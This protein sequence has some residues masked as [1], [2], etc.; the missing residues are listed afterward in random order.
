MNK[1]TN[2]WKHIYIA[3]ALALAYVIAR[4]YIAEL[5]TLRWVAVLVWAI[6]CA[7]WEYNQWMSHGCKKGYWQ[8]RGLDTVVDLGTGIGCFALIVLVSWSWSVAWIFLAT[9]IWGREI[10]G[11]IKEMVKG[12]SNAEYN[13]AE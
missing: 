6:L 3:T 8:R 7:S 9:V 11:W 5:H 10:W 13:K 1:L 12:R 4:H 2:T